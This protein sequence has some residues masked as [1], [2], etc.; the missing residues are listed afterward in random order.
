M[1]IT[2]EKIIFATQ[3]KEQKI[4]LKNIIFLTMEYRE[5]CEK[6]G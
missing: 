5:G 3:I 4:F 1:V 6:E 2:G